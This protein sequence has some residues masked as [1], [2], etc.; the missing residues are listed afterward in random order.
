ML[1][2]QQIQ[3]C[4]TPS[5]FKSDCSVVSSCKHTKPLHWFRQLDISHQLC[6]V[7]LYTTHLLPFLNRRVFHS[8]SLCVA[9]KNQLFVPQQGAHKIYISA[10]NPASNAPGYLMIDVHWLVILENEMIRSQEQ[11]SRAKVHFR[12]CLYSTHDLLQTLIFS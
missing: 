3:Y 6:K 4:D 9:E 2:N 1:C 8:V 10:G 11:G 7:N 12:D 5:Y